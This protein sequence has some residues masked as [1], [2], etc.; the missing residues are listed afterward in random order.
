MFFV[1]E[2]NQSLLSDSNFQFC[3]V[4]FLSL[5]FYFQSF[6]KGFRVLNANGLKGI[7]LGELVSQIEITSLP[8]IDDPVLLRSHLKYCAF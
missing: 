2:D 5:C 6:P 8:N 4:L 1:Y 7:M 3:G